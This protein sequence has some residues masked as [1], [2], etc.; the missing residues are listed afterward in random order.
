MIRTRF[1]RVSITGHATLELILIPGESILA[2]GLMLAVEAVAGS[3]W[4]VDRGR[5][6]IVT[7]GETHRSARRGSIAITNPGRRPV[8][9]R[10]SSQA[11]PSPP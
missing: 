4:I 5:D 1:P 2:A 11:A 6:V 3:V 7:A 9:I 10:L 8:T